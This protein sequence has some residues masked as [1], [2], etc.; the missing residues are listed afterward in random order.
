MVPRR[1]AYEGNWRDIFQNWEA[2]G[3]SH[4]GWV[5]HFILKFVNATTLDGF[6]PYRITREGIDWEVP[7]PTTLSNIGY[8]GDH[9]IT[10]LSRLL[11][12]SVNNPDRM[13]EGCRC[14]CSLLPTCPMLK[15]HQ[16]LVTDP[17]QSILFD[18]EQHESSETRR[19][20]FGSDG[21]L[22][23]DG[24]D[25]LQVTFGKNADPGVVQDVNVGARRWHLDVH[26]AAENDA[27]NAL[28]GYGLSMVTAS[29]L[30]RHVVL[31]QTLLQDVN[32]AR[33]FSGLVVVRVA[34][35][36]LLGRSC[37]RHPRF[38]GPSCGG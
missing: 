25:L 35:R 36:N 8:W 29:Y 1:L 21:R 7:S 2:L 10:Y 17:R 30:H 38:H 4:P 32:S 22:V 33:A 34:G 23:H 24:D 5:D 15:S 26:P 27:N 19:Q 13:R 31:L 9:Q 3:L 18:W 20:K 37:I 6:N 28:A 16:E 14:P 12:L 11:E